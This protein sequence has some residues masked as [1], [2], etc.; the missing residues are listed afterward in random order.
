MIGIVQAGEQARPDRFTYIPMVGLLI[1]I[2]WLA[3]GW[4]KLWPRSLVAMAG[5]AHICCGCASRVQA[6]YWEDSLTVFQHSLDV[7]GGD[8]Y[9]GHHQIEMYLLE[10]VPDQFPQAVE[11]LLISA[12]INPDYAFGQNNL[13]MAFIRAGRLEDARTHIERA[14]RLRP[15]FAE[16][17]AN[18]GSV[19]FQT[20]RLADAISH[21]QAALPEAGFCG[22]T[23]QSRRGALHAG[24][25]TA[26][27]SGTLRGRIASQPRCRHALQTSAGASANPRPRE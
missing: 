11:E 15:N 8:N 2:T 17:E 24:G 22:S 16:A 25:Q 1:A 4:L 13:G 7:T 27:S 6:Q 21:Y 12:K 18:L 5:V 10:N 26:R 3:A 20:G 23:L 19:F 14:L 9:I